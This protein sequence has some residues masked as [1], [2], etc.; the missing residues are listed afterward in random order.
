[1]EEIE[2][3]VFDEIIVKD[4]E[5][6]KSVVFMICNNE[7]GSKIL[8]RYVLN[9]EYELKIYKDELNNVVFDLLYS[10]G[11]VRF[12]TNRKAEENSMHQKV[13][14]NFPDFISVG[15][16]QPPAYY[17]LDSNYKPLRRPY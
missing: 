11:I 10:N 13:L 17:H 14:D 7:E 6:N 8:S 16:R 4:L 15:Y 9:Y 12:E 3:A 2:K 1:M 5:D